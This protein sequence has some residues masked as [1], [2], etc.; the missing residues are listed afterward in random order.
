MLGH[1]CTDPWLQYQ[2]KFSGQFLQRMPDIHKQ[3]N[4]ILNF[5][6]TCNS[7]TA[8]QCDKI[9]IIITFWSGN[10]PLCLLSRRVEEGCTDPRRVQLMLCQ[11]WL[12]NEKNMFTSNFC[13]DF[14][15]YTIP[16]EWERLGIRTT[17][18]SS[19]VDK[20]STYNRKSKYFWSFSYKIWNFCSGE[21][22]TTSTPLPPTL[23]AG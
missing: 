8:L 12:Q 20:C 23:P 3:T 22:K 9:W 16:E 18:T 10:C 7:K 21:P 15:V 1:N 11:V 4:I 6:E 13:S 14:F 17:P 5:Q 19:W 2:C